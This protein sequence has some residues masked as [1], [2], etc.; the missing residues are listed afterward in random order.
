MQYFL[1]FSSFFSV[2]VLIFVGA[3][4]LQVLDVSHNALGST[5]IDMLMKFL[6]P[7]ILTTLNFSS[8][9]E[10]K[11]AMSLCNHIASYF[12]EVSMLLVCSVVFSM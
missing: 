7:E 10:D 11:D 2:F 9:I 6:N 1:F 3:P 4:N 12:K 5:G 8:V